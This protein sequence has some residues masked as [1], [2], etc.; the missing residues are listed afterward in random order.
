MPCY[1]RLRRIAGSSVRP[2]RASR[3]NVRMSRAPTRRRARGPTRS[4]RSDCC[5]FLRRAHCTSA[6][7]RMRMRRCGRLQAATSMSV[8]RK[9][10]QRSMCRRM[11]T[12]SWRSAWTIRAG[13]RAA[14]ARATWSSTRMTASKLSTSS[15]ARACRSR[16][17]ATRR[18][19]STRSVRWMPTGI[20]TMPTRCA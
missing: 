17:W 14:S 6:A 7:S 16:R 3:R 12:S 10:R 4:R 11:R 15:T 18:C 20:S 1:L 8:S 9:S 2:L 5:T 13:C 19:G